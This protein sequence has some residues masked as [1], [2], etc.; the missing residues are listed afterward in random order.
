[1]EKIDFNTF[2][3]R[4]ENKPE[5]IGTGYS[6]MDQKRVEWMKENVDTYVIPT[7]GYPE[8]AGLRTHRGGRLPV[9]RN[10]YRRIGSYELNGILNMWTPT[11]NTKMVYWLFYPFVMWGKNFYQ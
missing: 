2:D 11:M 6:P 9:T 1:M 7:L 5:T 8:I 10:W 3:P 4:F